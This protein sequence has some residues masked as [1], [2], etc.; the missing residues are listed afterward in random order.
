MLKT[1]EIVYYKNVTNC[2]YG[3]ELIHL[4]RYKITNRALDHIGE[5]H[6]EVMGENGI[7]SSWYLSDDFITEIEMRRYKINKIRN[8]SK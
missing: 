4:N 8:V 7:I 1:G 2:I 3:W 6:Y 5:V